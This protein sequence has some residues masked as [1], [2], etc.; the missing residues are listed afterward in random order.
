MHPGARGSG[1]A[2]TGYLLCTA[3]RSGST[4][5]CGLLT[6]TGVAGVPKSY[7]HAPSVARWAAA[8]GLEADPPALSEVFA[9][10]RAAGTA[11]TGMFG[12]RVQAHSLRFLTARLA[13]FAPG[14]AG[15]RARLEAAF[16]PLRYV[17]LHRAD[18]L[19]QAVSCVIAEQTGL[20]HAAPDGREIE[21]SA[22]PAEPV[23][24]RAR[25]AAQL[26]QMEGWDRLWEA[27]F[28]AQGVEPLRLC[29]DGLSADPR[30]TLAELLRALGRDPAA[31]LGVSVATRKLADAVNRDWVRR[32][33]AGEGDGI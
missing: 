27:W 5:L 30:G 18:K 32:Y 6:A 9:A 21:R 31:A 20:W 26:A 8:L 28:A 10:V 12:L 11:D 13:E 3:P 4:L 17:Y 29:Y 22:P 23:Y 16:G 15:D 7:L 25:L 14:T 1:G 19:A 33:R 2:V 24:D